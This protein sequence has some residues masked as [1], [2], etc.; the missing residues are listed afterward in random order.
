MSNQPYSELPDAAAGWIDDDDD[1][2]ADES[3]TAFPPDSLVTFR[4][5]RDAVR[6]HI[7]IWLVLALIG[8]AGG[9]ATSVV[10]PPAHTS[11]ARML[12]TTREGED[13]TKAMATEVSLATTRTVAE[14]TIALLQLPDT[15]DQMLERYTATAL[16]DRVMEIKASAK[17]SEQATKLATVVAQTYLIFRKEQI[18]LQ[19]APLTRDLAAA[20]SEMTVAEQAVRSTGDNPDELQRPS[21]PEALKYIAARDKWMF[22]RQ[23]VLDQNV[24]ASKMN[25]SRMLDAPSPVLT[26]AK[27]MLAI[28]AGTGL[29]V[30]LFLG[31]GFV[32]VRALI[33]DR[34]WRRQ[35]IA[36][37]LGA[38]VRLSTGRPPRWQWIPFAHRLR[39]HQQHHPE[40]ELLVRHLDQRIIWAKRPTPALAVVSV[41][42][43]RSCAIAV[44]SLAYA[45]AEDGKNVLVADLTDSGILA[46]KLGVREI[47]TRDSQ[48]SEPTR[49]ITVHLPDPEAGP[50]EGCYLR[51][52]DNNR[53]GGSG[54]ISL[55][56]A[57]DVADVVLSLAT[58][59]PALGADH[60]G[61]WASRAAVVVT[62]GRSSL[63]K[64]RATGEMVRLAGLEIDT[65]VVLNADK[66]DEGVG[67]TEAESSARTLDVEMFGR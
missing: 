6:R 58:L 16:T 33:S 42:D 53:P 44:A 5:L 35:D 29:L 56:A 20:Q 1:L 48:F 9:L 34:L 39:K 46:A 52:G 55:D 11:S 51:L 63:T 27:R 43:V 36:Q 15:P 28:Q 67:V 8:L 30:G 2:Y 14:R 7:R 37:S 62:A 41:D 66:T 12:I 47:G 3:S 60:L 40:I 19:S 10:L 25:S 23:Q 65:A 61:S 57:W 38:R 21:S 26:S 18:A 45:L 31:I 59:T 24:S 32:I 13:P 54:D 17:T 50:A 64:V 4:F 49:R 22:V